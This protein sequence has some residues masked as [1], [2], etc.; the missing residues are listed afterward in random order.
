MKTVSPENWAGNLHYEK[1]LVG[2]HA[3][4]KFSYYDYQEA[5]MKAFFVGNC[6]HSW[7]IFFRYKFLL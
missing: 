6:S 3:Y 7:F 4:P 2:F 5:W 1:P